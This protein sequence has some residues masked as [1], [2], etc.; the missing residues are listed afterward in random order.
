MAINFSRVTFGDAPRGWTAGSI[1]PRAPI[2]GPVSN[3]STSGNIPSNI[4]QAIGNL[5][6]QQAFRQML[7]GPSM[8]PPQS[9]PI[10]APAP[11]PVALLQA[12]TANAQQQ[13]AQRAAQGLQWN[14]ANVAAQINAIPTGAGGI[15]PMGGVAGAQRAGLLQNQFNLQNQ[16][17]SANNASF[18]VPRMSGWQGGYWMGGGPPPVF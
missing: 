16:L 10:V 13:A 14:L 6:A 18:G 3:I 9:G 2:T 15:A 5:S 11:D 4:L 1:S 7:S 8:S 17:A 12:R